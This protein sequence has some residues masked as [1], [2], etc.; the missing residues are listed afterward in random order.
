MQTNIH[1]Q[2]PRKRSMRLPTLVLTMTL[3]FTLSQ[4]GFALAV[5]TFTKQDVIDHNAT[6]YNEW[7][8]VPGGQ[9]S[10]ELK[11]LYLKPTKNCQSDDPIIRET[12]TRITANAA[13]EYDKAAAINDWVATNIWYDWDDYYDESYDADYSAVATLGRGAGVCEGYANLTIALLQ[14]VGIPTRKVNGGLVGYN[15]ITSSDRLSF[16][17]EDL[18]S[19]EIIF[20]DP[21]ILSIFAS[22]AWCEAWVDGRWIIID[23]TYNSPN[24]LKNG[25]KTSDK[26]NVR[27]CFDISLENLSAN[28]TINTSTGYEPFVGVSSYYAGPVTVVPYAS[29]VFVDG[30][31]FSF[32]AYN[33]GGNNYFKLRDIAFVLADKFD[34][35]Y[36]DGAIFIMIGKAY[37]PNGSEMQNGDGMSK[38]ATRTSVLLTRNGTVFSGIVYP[39]YNIDGNNYLKL[40]DLAEYIGF[41]VDWRDGKVWIEKNESYTND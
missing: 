3:L 36:L 31:E 28:H 7:K 18:Y 15:S 19:S 34:V 4:T 17:G 2:N 6:L 12:A 29:T 24:S 30:V 1:P 26:R 22:H 13:S 37:T 14:A 39:A 27:R 41:D 11:E 35:D 38:A 21:G 33:I 23:T 20:N 40:R 16:N 32:N 25:Q 8:I 9:M 10:D 5:I